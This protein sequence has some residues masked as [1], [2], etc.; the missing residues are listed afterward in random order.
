MP[1]SLL[2]FSVVLTL[3]GA[4]RQDAFAVE[5]IVLVLAFVPVAAIEPPLLTYAMF[6]TSA[7]FT[8]VHALAVVRSKNSVP[9]S[10]ALEEFSFVL[11][12]IHEG[13][14]AFAVPDPV[15]EFSLVQ[16][17]HFG[18]GLQESSERF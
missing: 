2:E 9:M 5:E 15:C 16:G 4:A 8:V 12:P 18:K 14:F 7:P 11:V 17:P 6:L 13:Q 10:V 3:V 1:T